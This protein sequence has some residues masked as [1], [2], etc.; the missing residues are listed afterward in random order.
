MA[1]RRSF[2]QLGSIAVLGMP[3]RLAGTGPPSGGALPEATIAMTPDSTYGDVKALTFDTFGTVVDYRS[4]IIAEGEALGKARRLNVDW[5]RFAD[6]WR[7]GYAP[8]MNRVRTGQLPWTKLDALHRMTLDRLLDEFKIAGLSEQE[9]DHFNRVWHRL[10]PWPDAVSGLTRL[11]RKF[12]IAP[13]SNGNVS[14]LTNMAKHAGLPWDC[15]LGAELARHYKPDRETYLTA[16]ELLDLKPAEI[17]MVAAHQADLA[18]AHGLG[19]KTAFVPR[20]KEGPNGEK[21]QTPD[22]RWN[23][24][25]PDFNA[26]A[27]RLGA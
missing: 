3:A 8:A 11:K 12:V 24:V 21:N 18:A 6:A 5:P 13:L 20:P 23:V 16:A 22:P 7:S 4:T 15:I 17:M 25:A 26:L 14:L 9:I 2:L 1:N 27:A 19:F 10:K